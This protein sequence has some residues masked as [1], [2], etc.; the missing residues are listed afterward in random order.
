MCFFFLKKYHYFLTHPRIVP[1]IHLKTENIQKPSVGH[2]D[3]L[4]SNLVKS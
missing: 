1:P 2:E 4:L 3:V